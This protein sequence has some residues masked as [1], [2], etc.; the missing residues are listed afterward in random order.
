LRE[1]KTMPTY[2]F[3][4]KECGSKIVHLMSFEDYEKRVF[5]CPKCGSR[6][7][8]RLISTFQVKTSKKS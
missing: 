3:K 4:C 1:E 7:L 2:E 8:E 6:R 5:K